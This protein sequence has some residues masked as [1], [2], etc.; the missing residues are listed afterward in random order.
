MTA[1]APDVTRATL[2]AEPSACTRSQRHAPRASGDRIELRHIHNIWSSAAVATTRWCDVVD[3]PR[4]DPRADQRGPQARTRLHVVMAALSIVTSSA[5]ETEV[6]DDHAVD[7]LRREFA[8]PG[9]SVGRPCEQVWRARPE[10]AD[11]S[12]C[13]QTLVQHQASIASAQPAQKPALPTRADRPH[14]TCVRAIVRR[15]KDPP[16][17]CR[18]GQLEVVTDQ[19]DHPAGQPTI[20]SFEIDPKMAAWWNQ[21]QDLVE[22]RTC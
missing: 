6:V 12:R 4:T 15:S 22:L 1:D 11:C 5:E 17:A 9:K 16:R 19:T 20:G 14:H 2:S 18:H 8:N 3:R 10:P 7:A 13:E 21:R